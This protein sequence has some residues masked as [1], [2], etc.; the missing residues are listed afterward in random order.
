MDI[1]FLTGE[2]AKRARPL[3][4]ALIA[5]VIITGSAYAAIDAPG[6]YSGSQSDTEASVGTVLLRV[7]ADGSIVLG[8]S[9]SNHLHGIDRSAHGLSAGLDR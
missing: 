3:I 2:L 1:C 9:G 8:S 6:T 5:S 7:N 4:Y